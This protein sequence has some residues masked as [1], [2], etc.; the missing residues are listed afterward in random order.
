M[1]ISIRVSKP[2]YFAMPLITV[3][4]APRSSAGFDY[5]VDLGKGIHRPDPDAPVIFTL[6]KPP[7]AEP[8]NRIDEKEAIMPKNGEAVRVVL[9]APEHTLELKFHSD[10]MNKQRDGRYGWKLEV[11]VVGGGLR[12]RGDRFDFTAPANGYQQTDLIDMPVTLQRPEW[13]DDVERSYWVRFTDDLFGAIKVRMIAGGDHYSIVSGHINPKQGS[14][15]L[16]PSP[17]EQE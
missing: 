10:D 15:N 1:A 7:T 11:S 12:H 13:Q 16:V 2:G 3:D 6:F 5:G 4:D 8:L 17:S 14:R 9:D